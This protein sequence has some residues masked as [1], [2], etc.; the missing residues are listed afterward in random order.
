MINRIRWYLHRLKKKVKH[1]RFLKRTGLTQEQLDF[2]DKAVLRIY[3][4]NQKFKHDLK[5]YWTNGPDY[6][7]T[8]KNW[9]LT[10]IRE[11]KND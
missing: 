2:L 5:A 1:K 3:Y 10:K 9:N 7:F 8:G 4:G 6:L 11:D